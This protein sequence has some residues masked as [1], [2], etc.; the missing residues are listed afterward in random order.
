[1][2]Y[3]KI[4]RRYFLQGVGGSLLTLPLLP[5]LIPKAHA[6]SVAT[7]KNIIF[8]G[9]IH[10]GAGE[11]ADWFPA[12]IASNPSSNLLTQHTLFEQGGENNLD[13]IIR[14]AQLRNVLSSNPVHEAGNLDNNGERISFILGSFLNP[15]VDKI[16]IYR[17]ID[18]MAA[19]GHSEGIYMGQIYD[20]ANEQE[21][22][23]TMDQFL[24]QSPNFYQNR[25]TISN[26]VIISAN[27]ARYTASMLADGTVVLP[28]ATRSDALYNNIF[29]KYDKNKTPAEMAEE[30]R[31][32]FLIDRVYEDY[33]RLMSYAN[34]Q[35][36]RLAME[37]RRKIQE[38]AE[39]LTDIEKKTRT[40]I[41]SC[42]DVSS[43]GEIIDLRYKSSTGVGAYERAIDLQTDLM[44]AAMQCGASRIGTLFHNIEGSY[45]VEYHQNIAHNGGQRDKQVIHATHFRWQAEHLV[46]SVSRKLDALDQGDGK[47]LLDKSVVVWTHQCGYITHQAFGIGLMTVG[48]LDGYLKTGQYLDYRNLKNMGIVR[49]EGQTRRPGIPINQFWSTLLLGLGISPSEFELKGNRG[50]GDVTRLRYSGRRNGHFGYPTRIRQRLSQPLPLAT[51]N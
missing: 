48:S 45:P 11:G 28:S 19:G 24:A 40:I 17:G 51:N 39:F 18:T 1:M 12:P 4:S 26:P 23:P 29:G 9:S 5:S 31:R 42:S 8:I 36:R 3:N 14:S 43:P 25:E 20:D 46:A 15:F 47:T 16:N 13:H 33:K 10:G 35:G 22:W 50:Y 49:K 38:H 41:N 30:S 7:P 34:P 27:P 37:D 32:S 44:V 6:Q 21:R 2:K